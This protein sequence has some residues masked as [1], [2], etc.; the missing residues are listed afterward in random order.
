MQEF[1]SRFWCRLS[2]GLKTMYLQ[3]EEEL[4]FFSFYVRV[5]QLL[6]QQ[7][8][9]IL[10][11]EDEWKTRAQSFSRLRS[12]CF[13]HFKNLCMRS[14]F[15]NILSLL[16]SKENFKSFLWGCLIEL[17]LRCHH[18]KGQVNLTIKNHIVL[19]CLSGDLL[20]ID[21]FHLESFSTPRF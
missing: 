19:K 13:H 3:L 16:R 2:F 15:K 6:H 10:V 17:Y 12:E 21:C 9:R 11:D 20:S 5:L 14:H 4:S 7:T 18:P 8:R 1:Q